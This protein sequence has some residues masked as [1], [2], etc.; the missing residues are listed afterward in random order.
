MG[1]GVGKVPTN[2][3]LVEAVD[4]GVFTVLGEDIKVQEPTDLV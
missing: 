2:I 3:V 4:D 1:R